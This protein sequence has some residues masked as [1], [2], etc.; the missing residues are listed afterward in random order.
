MVLTEARKRANEKWR[1]A[2]K[3]YFADYYRSKYQ[4]DDE[5]RSRC[6]DGCRRRRAAQTEINQLMSIQV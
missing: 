5:Y 2:N 3:A 6:K 1:Q 4:S